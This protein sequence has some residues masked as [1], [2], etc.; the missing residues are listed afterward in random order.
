MKLF[1]TS[2]IWQEGNYYIAYNPELEVAS[3]G[4]T[5]SQAETR[6]REAVNAFLKTTRKKGTIKQVLREAGFISEVKGWHAP[7]I[8]I[9]SLEVAI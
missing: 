2:K 3:Q 8:S 5:E 7:L 6:L 1:L 4:K 9:S